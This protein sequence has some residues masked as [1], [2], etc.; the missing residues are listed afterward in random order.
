V[1][2]S[3]TAIALPSE[4]NSL[5]RTDMVNYCVNCMHYELL[6]DGDHCEW[7]INFFYMHGRMP[8]PGESV[9]EPWS[10]AIVRQYQVSHETLLR[11]A[12]HG[13][14]VLPPRNPS[15]PPA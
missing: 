15:I 7:C 3:T 12:A 5:D 10:V 4:Q 9:P 14:T 2:T 6:A 11:E 13:A 8:R 1:V